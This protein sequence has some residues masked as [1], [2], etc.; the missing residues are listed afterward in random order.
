MR[1]LPIRFRSSLAVATLFLLAGA[2]FCGAQSTSKPNASTGDPVAVQEIRA[3]IK[4]YATSVDGLNLALAKQVW[5]DAPEVTFIHPRGTEKGLPQV[6]TNFYGNT[7]GTFSKRELLVDEPSIHVY[8]DTAWSE[9]TWT[10][11]A[12]VKNDAPNITTRGRE[13]QVYHK[14]HGVWRIVHV[15]YSGRPVT[16]ELK[17]FWL[18]FATRTQSG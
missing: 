14:D 12:T 7:M 16:G 13:T 5:S 18:D 4:D 15:H 3:L 9:F 8:H 2:L 11:H 17:G 6:L 1:T 10:F